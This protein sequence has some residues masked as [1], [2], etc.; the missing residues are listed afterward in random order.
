MSISTSTTR[1]SED[2]SAASRACFDV[3]VA[4]KQMY[5]CVCVSKGRVLYIYICIV[6]VSLCVL[7]LVLTPSPVLHDVF[8][9]FT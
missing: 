2:S 6:E 3:E 8:R 4:Y 1:P 5:V 7:L 9:M